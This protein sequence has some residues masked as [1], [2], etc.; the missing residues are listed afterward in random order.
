MIEFDESFIPD[1]YATYNIFVESSSPTGEILKGQLNGQPLAGE[2][3]V[4]I[5]QDRVVP[6]VEIQV[7][8]DL[9]TE[10]YIPGQELQVQ[11]ETRQVK[12][13]LEGCKICLQVSELRDYTAGGLVSI[14]LSES[15]REIP[16][17][18]AGEKIEPLI[19]NVKPSGYSWIETEDPA[20]TYIPL[21][22]SARAEVLKYGIPL[23]ESNVVLHLPPV[24][25]I[26]AEW[27]GQG[28]P[29]EQV[30]PETPY[31]INLVIAALASDPHIHT[32]Q[33]SVRYTEQDPEEWLFSGLLLFIPCLF[34]LCK[35]EAVVYTQED[36]ITLTTGDEITYSIPIQLPQEPTGESGLGGYYMLALTFDGVQIWRGGKAALDSGSD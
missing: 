29:V 21:E 2:D 5:S 4:E 14:V 8:W 16:D 18:T 6:R 9:P 24:E 19:L 10:G 20:G 34:G 28:A 12:G 25:V 30:R 31:T 26:F 32:L 33:L 13:Q 15:C 22:I 1:S 11:M 36:E 23:A 17:G 3:G 7:N 27:E 35:D